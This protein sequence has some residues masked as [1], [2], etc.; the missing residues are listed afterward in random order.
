VSVR[1]SQSEHSA[2]LRIMEEIKD[3]SEIGRERKSGEEMG[4]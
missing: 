3:A 4:L 1:A 2:G